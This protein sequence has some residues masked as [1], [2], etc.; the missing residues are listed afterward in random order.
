MDL[1]SSYYSLH[2]PHCPMLSQS[3][4]RTGMPSEANYLE[5]IHN[6]WIGQNENYSANF[7]YQKQIS[8]EKATEADI[9]EQS[10]T[11]DG[12]LTN[13]RS[14]IFIKIHAKF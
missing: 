14:L 3:D 9:E 5:T 4:S 12:K 11:Q 13:D 6:Y 10:E 7:K 8:A 2:L 1:I